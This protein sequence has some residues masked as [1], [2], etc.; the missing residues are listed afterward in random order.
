MGIYQERVSLSQVQILES[1]KFSL[2]ID[3]LSML[4]LD[5][6]LFLGAAKNTYGTV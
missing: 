5:E 4:L 3:T 6:F 2:K 1:T